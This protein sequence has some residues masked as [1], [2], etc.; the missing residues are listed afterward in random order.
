MH[1]GWQ[2]KPIFQREAF[3]RRDAWVWLIEHAAF[4]PTEVSV[5]RGVV[6]VGRGQ[7]CYS[8]RYMA[9]AWGW[10][11]ARVRRFLSRATDCAMIACVADAGQTLITICNYE[12][13]QDFK[14]V[15]DA[16]TDAG[17]TQARRSGDANKNEDKELKEDS[18]A[19][20][21]AVSPETSPDDEG[22]VLDLKREIWKRGRRLLEKN[23]ISAAKAG[24]LLGK[25]RKDHGDVAL[26][27]ALSAAEAEVAQDIVPFITA[28]LTRSSGNGK[29]SKP[30]AADNT[31]SILSGLANA[32][33]AQG[34]DGGDPECPSDDRAD[35]SGSD[36]GGEVI[37]AVRSEAGGYDAGDDA[38]VVRFAR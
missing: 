11:D 7:L 28:C 19:N 14:R 1:R 23:G 31:R 27:N 3:S 6:S 32:L 33:M 15:G 26:L 17:A 8:L 12:S 10:D 36:R 16:P 38:R 22:T 5:G 13:Y 29:S 18:N 9:K 2:D 20:A 30:S 34:L 35:F 21:L 25:W 37:D 4:R 24:P